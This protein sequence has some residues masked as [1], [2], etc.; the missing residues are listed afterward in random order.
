MLCFFLVLLVHYHHFHIFCKYMFLLQ[1]TSLTLFYFWLWILLSIIRTSAFFYY[2]LSLIL[3]ILNES[4]SFFYFCC[5]LW[6][7]GKVRI[8]DVWLFIPSNHVLILVW[9]IIKLSRLTF[10]PLESDSIKALSPD[11]IL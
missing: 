2:E 3:F 1:A 10:A 9:V 4:L 6:S 11:L 7:T 8:L 5:W